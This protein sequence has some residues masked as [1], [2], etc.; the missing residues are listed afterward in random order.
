MLVQEVF[1]SGIDM[2]V[3]EGSWTFCLILNILGNDIE[4]EG[5]WV[6]ASDN[7]DMS[8]I[9]TFW[10]CSSGYTRITTGADTLILGIFDNHNGGAWCD[11]PES[12]I[13]HFICEGIQ[14]CLP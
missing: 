7:S 14:T 12:Y 2:M 1:L 5:V 13:A 11:E 3:G 9:S 4:V 10:T 6:H 8:W